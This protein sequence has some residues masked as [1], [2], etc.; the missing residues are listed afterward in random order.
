AGPQPGRRGPPPGVRQAR[1]RPG[2]V[3]AAGAG[4]VIGAAGGVAAT[5]AVVA[6]RA[7][8]PPR[9]GTAADRGPGPVA[10][11]AAASYRTAPS[12]GAVPGGGRRRAGLHQGSRGGPVA[13]RDQEVTRVAGAG[14]TGVSDDEHAGVLVGAGTAV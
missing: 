14:R 9:G 7:G 5:G 10:G 12:P 6:Q 3:V 8:H 11:E 2:G 4:A 13:S 1:G